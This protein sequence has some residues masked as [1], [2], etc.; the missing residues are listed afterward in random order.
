MVTPL[1]LIEFGL[2][3][4]RQDGQFCSNIFCEYVFDWLQLGCHSTRD[5]QFYPSWRFGNSLRKVF[6]WETK[7][8]LL[9]LW[10]LLLGWRK[11]IGRELLNFQSC[12]Q[13]VFFAMYVACVR[14]LCENNTSWLACPVCVIPSSSWFL[15]CFLVFAL[16]YIKSPPLNNSSGNLFCSLWRLFAIW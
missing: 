10:C 13:C 9:A 1:C 11:G 5:E 16:Q 2:V 4:R 7:L 3:H 14:I 15:Q 6:A 12:L 8:Q